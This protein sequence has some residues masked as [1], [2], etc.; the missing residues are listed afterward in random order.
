MPGLMLEVGPLGSK[1]F[2]GGFVGK[3][4]WPGPGRLTKSAG[5][6]GKRGVLPF[7][8]STGVLVRSGGLE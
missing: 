4:Y 2:P 1:A 3:E 5:G 7:A 6:S 8:M